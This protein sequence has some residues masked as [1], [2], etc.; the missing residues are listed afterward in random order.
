MEMSV[1]AQTMSSG[2]MAGA[3]PEHNPFDPTSLEAVLSETNSR[4]PATMFGHN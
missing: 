2:M 1:S 3:Y 4:I